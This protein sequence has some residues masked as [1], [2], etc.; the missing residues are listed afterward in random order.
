MNDEL[1]AKIK[2][3]LIEEKKALLLKLSNIEDI[4]VEGDEVD[5]I[6]GNLIIGLS[7]KL[8][9]RDAHKVFLINHALDKIENGKYGLCEECEEEIPEKRLL[10]NACF[11]VCV[12]CAEE[13]ELEM[14]RG[15]GS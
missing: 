10:H 2:N 3:D 12:L 15:N 1:L 9:E 5:I 6:Q 4:D 8:N 11:R 13:R 7:S 14:R